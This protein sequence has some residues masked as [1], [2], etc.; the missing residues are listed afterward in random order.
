MSRPIALTIPAVIVRSSPKGFPIAYAGS[1]TSTRSSRRNRSGRS[2]EAGA[3]F[4]RTTAMSVDGS[5]P[6]IFAGYDAPP[7]K[8]DANVLRSLDDVVVGDDVAAF[9]DDEAGAERGDLLPLRRAEEGR[10]H[11]LGLTVGDHDDT[12]RIAAI[13]LLR[14]EAPRP[15]GRTREPAGPTSSSRPC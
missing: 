8:P 13:D 5:E 10:R 12:G 1:P 3:P 9:V 11:D 2:T 4:T 14:V 7:L 6:T 15:L